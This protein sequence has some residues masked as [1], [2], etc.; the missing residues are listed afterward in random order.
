MLLRPAGTYLDDWYAVVMVQCS[1]SAW[2]C[3]CRKP[4]YLFNRQ[5]LLPAEKFFKKITA[6][7]SA[8]LKSCTSVTA[9]LSGQAPF[10]LQAVSHWFPYRKEKK[11]DDP[12]L[13]LCQHMLSPIQF[14]QHDIADCRIFHRLL[15]LYKLL[16]RLYEPLVGILPAWNNYDFPGFPVYPPLFPFQIMGKIP[17]PFI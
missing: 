12:K 2:S 4:L 7:L 15:F 8:F 11:I 14:F 17:L 9:A 13:F 10:F 16:F 5:E 3:I 6:Y 1:L